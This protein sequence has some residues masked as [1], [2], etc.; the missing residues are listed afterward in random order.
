MVQRSC[1]VGSLAVGG[2]GLGAAMAIELRE[3]DR[4][5]ERESYCVCPFQ[6]RGP[7]VLPHLDVIVTFL[8]QF[9]V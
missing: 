4:E 9:I 5:S 6:P 8:H 1:S 3:T 2:L 7:S